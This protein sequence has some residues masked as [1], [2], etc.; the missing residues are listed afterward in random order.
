MEP[1]FSQLRMR[2]PRLDNTNPMRNFNNESTLRQEYN[3]HPLIRDH[4]VHPKTNYNFK[5]I[6]HVAFAPNFRNPSA[7]RQAGNTEDIYF[8]DFINQHPQ[9]KEIYKMA[10]HGFSNYSDEKVMANIAKC[11]KPSIK[12]CND[13][14]QTSL[15]YTLKMF[16]HLANRKFSH[17]VDYNPNTANGIPINHMINPMTG[18]PY[19]NK[20]EFYNSTDFEKML[21]LKYLAVWQMNHKYEFLPNIELLDNKNRLYFCGDS[22]FCYKQKALYDQQDKAMKTHV[23]TSISA[24]LVMDLLNNMVVLMIWQEHIML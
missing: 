20:K 5:Y 12:P 23:M 22:T 16:Q 10:D 24:G 4:L 6:K 3:F 8:R 13:E 19:K 7:I 1:A 18:K 2:Q 14:F 17:I 21:A 15:V 9:Y 11:D